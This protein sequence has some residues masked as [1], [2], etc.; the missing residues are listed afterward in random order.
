VLYALN[1]H[2]GALTWSLNL[3]AHYGD[4]LYALDHAPLVADFDNDGKKDVFIVGGYGIY[5]TNMSGN[6]GRAY[7]IS[8]AV[9][10]GPDL[11]MFQRDIW[12]QSS[13]CS[14]AI[15]TDVMAAKP[16][17]ENEVE[18]FPN[19]TTD[20]F[21]RL[22]IEEFQKLRQVRLFSSEGVLVNS[23]MGP[24]VS[25]LIALHCYQ[26]GTYFVE[27]VFED[28]VER[29]KVIVLSDKE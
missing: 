6:F 3:A 20:G 22:R 17:E 4:P 24:Y 7:M 19:P 29:K 18:L 26:S 2:N 1:G 10:N 9:G 11:L 14:N 8:T 21:V 15:L 13:L 25:K 27:C 16:R 12:R 28:K 23:L 5:G